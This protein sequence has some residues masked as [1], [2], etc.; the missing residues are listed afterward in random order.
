MYLKMAEE[1]DNTKAKRWQKNNDSFLIFVSSP[2][3]FHM[4][5]TVRLT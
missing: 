2:I 5:I 4:A 3:S 1:G